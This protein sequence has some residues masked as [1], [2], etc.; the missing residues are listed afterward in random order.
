MTNLISQNNIGSRIYFIRQKKVM[1]DSD[2]AELYG[3]KTKALNQ[4]VRRNKERFPKDF[5]FQLEN[6]ELTNLRCQFGTSSLPHGGRRY[7]PYV[8]TEQGVAM[9]SSVLRSKRAIQVNIQI[10]RTFLR[11]RD[12]LSS[13]EDLSRKLDALENKYDTQFKVVF[14]AIRKMMESPASPREKIGFREPKNKNSSV[15]PVRPEPFRLGLP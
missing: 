10:M 14:D 7:F 2:L 3:V 12:I 15:P 13:H 9:L 1:L 8:F 11:L 6:Q 4:A 5:V